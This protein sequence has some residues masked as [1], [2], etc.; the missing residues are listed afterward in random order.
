RLGDTG[1]E[2]WNLSQAIDPRPVVPDREAKSIGA[3]E[4]FEEDVAA[5]AGLRPHIHDQALRVGQRLRRAGLRARVVQLKI[6][7][8]DFTVLTRRTTFPAA[9][10]DGQALYR[11]AIALL[12]ANPPG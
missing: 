10:D 2:L 5:P 11:A 6:K 9:T 7:L 1:R 12:D 4:T 3:E 8:R